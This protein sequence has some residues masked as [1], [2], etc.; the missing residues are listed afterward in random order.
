MRLRRLTGRSPVPDWDSDPVAAVK[1]DFPDS[2]DP[3]TL[4]LWDLAAYLA[5]AKR[6]EDIIPLSDEMRAL[7]AA[8]EARR[9]PEVDVGE[10]AP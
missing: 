3:L 10:A 9:P 4:P 6:A 2:S 8:V 5:G 1:A 7:T